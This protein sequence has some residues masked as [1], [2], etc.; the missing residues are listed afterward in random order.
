MSFEEIGKTA[1]EQL[2]ADA[3]T[4]VK[5][6]IAVGCDAAL[7]EAFAKLKAA[8][9]GSIDD[10]II[11]MVAPKLKELAKAELLALADKI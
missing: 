9:P 2:K 6:Q 7:D 5:N 8:I 1:L 11:E 4:L 10:S 3:K